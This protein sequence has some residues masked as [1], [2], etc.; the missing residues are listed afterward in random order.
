MKKSQCPDK[1]MACKKVCPVDLMIDS[2][3]SH[4]GECIRCG[5]CISTCPRKNILK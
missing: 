4:Q 2:T 1:C 3:D 5:K